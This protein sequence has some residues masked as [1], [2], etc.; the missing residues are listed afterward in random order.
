MLSKPWYGTNGAVLGVYCGVASICWACGVIKPYL[1]PILA[2]AKSDNAGT[3]VSK[4]PKAPAPAP[5]KSN[6]E[7]GAGASAT[8]L[9]V[10]GNALAYLPTKANSSVIGTP[11]SNCLAIFLAS[12]VPVCGFNAFSTV[13]VLA[14]YFLASLNWVISSGDMAQMVLFLAYIVE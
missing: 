1:E 14:I 4:S 6:T 3:P 12:T 9:V 5:Y 13:N 11:W 10:F 7:N 8:T 2:G